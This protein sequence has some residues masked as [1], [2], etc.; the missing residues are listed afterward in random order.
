[1]RAP[2]L[3]G[4]CIHEEVPEVEVQ[5]IVAKH[6]HSQAKVPPSEHRELQRLALRRV[7]TQKLLW[8]WGRAREITESQVFGKREGDCPVLPVSPF[9]SLLRQMPEVQGHKGVSAGWKVKNCIGTVGLKPGSV[10]RLDFQE[11]AKQ[12]ELERAPASHILA[13]CVDVGTDWGWRER[14]VFNFAEFKIYF[15]EV[16]KAGV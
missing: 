13:V 3:N 8:H 4:G 6:V 5:G 7:T 16:S 2:H 11:R 10:H 1:M 15:K 12:V 9:A 14:L